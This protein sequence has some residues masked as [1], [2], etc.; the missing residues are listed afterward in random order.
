MNKNKVT[1]RLP[2]IILIVVLVVLCIMMLLPFFWMFSTSLRLPKESFKM[3]P[4]FFPTSFR[5]ENYA[6]V[7]HS[8]PFLQF[9]LNSL[10]VSVIVVICNIFVTTMAAFA[11]SRLNF[12]FRE[13]LFLLF[14]AG[15]MIPS[16]ATI[17]PQF[18]IMSKLHLVG[19]LWSL[20]LPA[21]TTPL[22]IFLVRQY[23]MTIPKSYEEA[24]YIDGA[25]RFK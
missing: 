18:I 19:E 25:G 24:A 8:F 3:P 5:W 9:I 6:E 16:Q 7:F 20:I 12:K 15:M 21:V 11:F 2:Q 4:S 10:F 1:K 23:M 13:G 17:I 14:L 22:S